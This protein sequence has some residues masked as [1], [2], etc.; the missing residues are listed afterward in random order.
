MSDSQDASL[1]EDVVFPRVSESSPEFYYSEP[2]RRALEC[3]LSAGPAAF[4]TQLSL[5]RINNFLSES[6][7]SELHNHVTD[8][9]PTE[10]P[11]SSWKREPAECLSDFSERYWPEYSDVPAPCLDLGWPDDGGGWKGIT[12]ATVYTHPPHEREP[13]IREVMRRGIQEASKLV[14][15]VTDRLTDGDVFRDL[16]AV[17]RRGVAVYILLEQRGEESF[18][19]MREREGERGGGGEENMRVRVVGGVS[20]CSHDGKMVSGEMK[21]K[22]ILID[23]ETVIT[24]SYS[25]TWSDA[26]LHR[27]LITVLK[28]QVIDSFDREFRMLYASSLPVQLPNWPR[29]ADTHPISYNLQENPMHSTSER[30]FQPLHL[31]SAK[32]PYTP[33]QRAPS[34]EEQTTPNRQKWEERAQYPSEGQSTNYRRTPFQAK[35]EEESYAH[36]P[37]THQRHTPIG[38]EFVVNEEGSYLSCLKIN[39]FGHRDT[40]REEELVKFDPPFQ[41]KTPLGQGLNHRWANSGQ[42]E[43]L[44]KETT[45][46]EGLTPGADN[47]RQEEGLNLHQHH[48]QRDTP[49][50][51]ELSSRLDAS[52]E[53]GPDSTIE[54]PR[55]RAPVLV[56]S[57][58]WSLSHRQSGLRSLSDILRAGRLSSTTLPT[59]AGGLGARGRGSR[60]LWDLSQLSTGSNEE[61]EEGGDPEIKPASQDKILQERPDWLRSGHFGPRV[62][63]AMALIRHRGEEPRLPTVPS[64]LRGRILR[65]REG[66]PE[67]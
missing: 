16:V 14:A 51:E 12:R 62:T 34:A 43:L 52:K 61:E 67:Y 63:P 32:K 56:L 15:V 46:W 25:L 38:E 47:S 58:P 45:S 31:L 35:E 28:G 39:R 18:R 6:E 54:K 17:A 19:E 10:V 9:V 57:V 53:E 40:P 50:G 3:L 27:Q 48:F 8:F 4:H 22:F 59:P 1:D 23:H 30:L 20:F 55:Q 41:R 65:K 60:S 29:G 66:A 44:I 11:L 49:P 42:E 33:D 13:P 21:E 64:R 37:P 36:S 2:R 7:I 24:G 5:E 26:H